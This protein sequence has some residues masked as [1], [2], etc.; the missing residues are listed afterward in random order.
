MQRGSTYR[1]TPVLF[2]SLTPTE[3][4]AEAPSFLQMTGLGG[5]Q[6][7]GIDVSPPGY[8]NPNY[9]KSVSSLL[10]NIDRDRRGSGAN[11]I[12][13][14]MNSLSYLLL[15][16]RTRFSLL[17]P[18]MRRVKTVAYTRLSVDVLRIGR[19]RLYFLP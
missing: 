16:C 6:A 12:A 9:L 10:E 15:R 11:S 17:W 5:T 4:T 3:L 13:S 2:A 19:V 14:D 8:S 7:R 1:R 18:E